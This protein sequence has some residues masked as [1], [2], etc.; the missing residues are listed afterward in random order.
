MRP[1][2][3][4]SRTISRPWKRPTTS[5]VRSS[6]VGPRP[7]LVTITS[8]PLDGEELERAL[9]VLGPVAD[10]ERERVVDAE[11]AQAVGQPRPVAVRHPPG[12][13]LGAGDDD[14][15]A[16]AHAPQLGRLAAGSGR[17]RPGGVTS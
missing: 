17:T 5:A 3:A 11:L 6:A 10:D 8:T 16:G 15:R 13:H 14:A 12:Q 4:S 7:P 2:S 9:H 1:S